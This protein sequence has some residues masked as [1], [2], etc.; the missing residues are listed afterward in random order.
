MQEISYACPYFN[1]GRQTTV[2]VQKPLPEEDFSVYL[3]QG[4]RKSGDQVYKNICSGC[5]ACVPIRVLAE[6]FR[7]SKSQ[8]RT[9]KKCEKAG[10]R[11]N[12]RKMGT[13]TPIA[14]QY[15]KFALFE[16]YSKRKHDRKENLFS[17]F[18]SFAALH[19]PLFPAYEMEYFIEGKLIGVG[20]IDEGS[21]GFSSNYFYYDTDYLS[22]RLGI[23]SLIQ[24][25]AFARRMGKRYHYLGFWI[26]ECQKMSY[27]ADFK[28]HELLMAGEWLSQKPNPCAQRDEAEERIDEND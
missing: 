23:F 14:N 11:L 24:E 25:I 13:D 3:Q 1:D 12:I 16:K 4:F 7:L 9:L 15:Q 27:K 20:I 19:H 28:P 5:L 6:E 21:D 2:L 22:L 17:S 18:S 10:I 26:Q 8:K